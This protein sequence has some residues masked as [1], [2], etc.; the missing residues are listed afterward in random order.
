VTHPITLASLLESRNIKRTA[1]GDAR[2]LA[3]AN[4]SARPRRESYSLPTLQPSFMEAQS[5]QGHRQWM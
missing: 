1:Y 2:Q 5:W 3:A 4:S